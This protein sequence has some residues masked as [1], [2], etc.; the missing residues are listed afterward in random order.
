MLW[1]L[2]P[3]QRKLET[4]MSDISEKCYCA[5]WISGLEYT[6]WYAVENGPLEYG[7]GIVT[8]EEIEQLKKLSQACSCWIFMDDDKEETAIELLLW[9]QKY[10]EFI[11]K[12]PV[13]IIW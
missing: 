5:G 11:S 8:P 2:T 12:Y 10:D 13:G 1:D 3:E 7:H 6:L 9:K 4:F